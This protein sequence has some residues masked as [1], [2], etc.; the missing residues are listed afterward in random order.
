MGKSLRIYKAKLPVILRM[1]HQATAFA[2]G[3][4]EPLEPF[5]YESLANPLPLNSQAYGYRDEEYFTLKVFDLPNIRTR[6]DL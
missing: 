4:L 5:T 1:A 6:R 2:S 3:L